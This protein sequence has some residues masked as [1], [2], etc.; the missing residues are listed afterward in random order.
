MTDDRRR[1]ARILLGFGLI[2]LLFLGETVV[3][4]QRLP[5]PASPWVWSALG[6][7]S[8]ACFAAAAW[9]SRPAADPGPSKP[10]AESPT[11]QPTPASPSP[12][13]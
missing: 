3:A 4:H 10:P 11:P 7:G 12:P 6:L 8:L 13:P 1:R 9:M 5:N 2:L